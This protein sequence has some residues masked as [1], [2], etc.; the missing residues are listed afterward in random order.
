MVGLVL[1]KG[2]T[3]K[4]RLGNTALGHYWPE[5]KDPMNPSK[6]GIREVIATYWAKQYPSSESKGQLLTHKVENIKRHICKLGT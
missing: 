2:V 5:L 6:M 1:L 4:E 3:Y